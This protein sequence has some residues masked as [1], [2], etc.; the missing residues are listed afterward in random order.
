VA[1]AEW[2]YAH[3]PQSVMAEAVDDVRYMRLGAL[4]GE[5]VA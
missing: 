1:Q 5:R 2:I 4:P 3:L